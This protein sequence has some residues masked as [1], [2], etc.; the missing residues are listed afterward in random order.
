MNSAYFVSFRKLE[1]NFSCLFL[2]IELNWGFFGCTDE[3]FS[4]FGC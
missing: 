2:L 4:A 1:S 3:L